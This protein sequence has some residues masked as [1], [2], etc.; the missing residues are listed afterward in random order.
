[1]PERPL[2]I[3]FSLLHAGYLRH[4]GQPIRILASRGHL[5]HLALARADAKDRGDDALLAQL[6]A[7]C[8]TVTA[9]E[10]PRRA[11]TDGWRPLAWLVRA[12]MD[13]L[14]YAEP[15][16]R[17]APTLRERT[18]GKVRERI[19]TSH[20][21]PITR[22]L[23]LRT[24][25]WVAGAPDLRRARMFMRLLRLVEAAIPTTPGVDALLSAHR[26]DLVLASPVV[27]I[28]SSQIE[29][30][31]SA[32]RAGIP[33]AVCVASWDNLT[34]KGL[35]RLTPDRVLVWNEL[36]RRELVEMHD[37]P[38]ERVVVTGGQKFDPW[39]AREPST[40]RAELVA[41]LGFEADVPFVLYLCSSSFIA[42]DEVTFVRRWVAALR[43]AA[44]EAVAR[45]GIVVRP[46]PQNAAQWQG[47]DLDELPNTAIWPREGEYPDAGDALSSFYD[48]LAHSA[49]VVGV[50][51][52]AMIEAAIVGRSVLT[53]LDPAFAGTQEGTLHFHYLLR[54]QG[55][56]LGVA[57][58]LDEHVR[59]LASVLAGG[60]AEQARVQEFVGA[61]V[62]PHGLDR[63]VAPIV[64]DE[65][66]TCAAARPVP[67]GTGERAVAAAIRLALQAPVAA[68]T[69]AL[70]RRSA[71]YEGRLYVEPEAPG[72]APPRRASAR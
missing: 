49:V 61:F 56:F 55:G 33:C 46:H 31:K 5:V 23:V 63:A 12:L 67:L 66:E 11:P 22:R 8:P 7:D 34:N 64:A 10:A 29:F 57:R 16:Y 37:V 39:F 62:R 28:G 6:L 44:D 35:L 20:V 47:V 15:R 68:S 9:A 58:D 48:A 43:G 52:S 36:Q 72:A 38:A 41:R 24:L 32:R 54:E 27:E 17:A 71:R 45:L 1:M 40:T 51:T 4:Y 60:A 13:V 25:A 59:Q 3:V 42:P 19:T 30:L 26:A 69:L 70:R 18:A 2:R 53:V 21:D 14:R 65:I 50:N